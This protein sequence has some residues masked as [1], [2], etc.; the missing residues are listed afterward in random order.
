MAL[1]ESVS[2]LFLVLVAA[3]LSAF[4]FEEAGIFSAENETPEKIKKPS[5]TYSSLCMAAPVMKKSFFL[6]LYPKTSS[7]GRQ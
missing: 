7:V 4:P 3:R 2:L 6:F 1:S 5:G